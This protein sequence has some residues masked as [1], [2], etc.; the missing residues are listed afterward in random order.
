LVYNQ[1]L[2]KNPTV[3]FE[4][5]VF[6]SLVDAMIEDIKLHANLSTARELDLRA[7]KK[8]EIMFRYINW[9]KRFG[10]AHPAKVLQTKELPS[11]AYFAKYEKIIDIIRIRLERGLSL[12]PFLSQR[13]L[14]KP[15]VVQSRSE[16]ADKDRLLNSENIY[17]LHL[18]TSFR[19]DVLS[20]YSG[21]LLFFTH[22]KETAYL[23]GIGSHS[24]F[25]SQEWA[26]RAISNWPNTG[27]F[28]EIKGMRW[29]SYSETERAQLRK[30]GVSVVVNLGGK[31]YFSATGSTS[32]A[33]LSVSDQ[34][35]VK[36]LLPQIKNVVMQLC[37]KRQMT[38]NYVTH[39]AKR[40]VTNVTLTWKVDKGHIELI[41]KTTGVRLQDWF[42]R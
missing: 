12:V 14:E 2:P 6:D 40:T 41:D 8:W 31:S 22:R 28:T 37:R 23:L 20:G 13:V 16:N 34:W 7:K 5:S 27:M 35:K 15:Y 24:D 19:N 3:S 33:G 25:D 11:D 17:H 38:A 1:A 9:C 32:T 29:P 10:P 39:I 21:D 30:S 36:H 18:G 4:S 42:L 26:Q